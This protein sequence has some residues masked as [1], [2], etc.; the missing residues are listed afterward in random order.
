MPAADDVQ[1][2]FDRLLDLGATEHE[3]PTARGEGFNTA[4]VI[5]PFGNVLGVMENPHY[6]D[7][8]DKVA[9]R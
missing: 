3:K 7:M 1:A 6:M 5:D 9:K 4:T 2:A 8:L